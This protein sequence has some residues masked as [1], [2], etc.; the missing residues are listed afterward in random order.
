MKSTITI[1]LFAC[2]FIT[3]FSQTSFPSYGKIDIADLQMK[4]CPI[5]AGSDAMVLLD[6][7]DIDY[8]IT[9]SGDIKL[10]I[11]KRIRIKIFNNKG[12]KRANIK[13]PYLYRKK[14]TKISDV[15]GIIYSI[16]STGRITTQKI[17]KGQIFK[18]KSEDDIK[19]VS[20]TFPNVQPGSVIEYRYTRTE[21][22]SIHLVPW[23][24]Q[25]DIPVRLSVYR[26]AIPYLS[27]LEKNVVTN[28]PVREQKESLYSALKNRF[29]FS[30][31]NIYAFKSE[32][33][34]GSINDNL[35]RMEFF[36]KPGRFGLVNARLST[37]EKWAVI[38]SIFTDSSFFGSHFRKNI[39]STQYILDSAGRLSSPDEKIGYIYHHVKSKMKWDKVRTF[40][41]EDL[42]ECWKTKSGNS[43]EINLILLNLL[44]KCNIQAHALLTSTHEN[45]K[46]NK[47]FP[48]PGQFNGVA[49]FARDTING[50][51][52]VLDGTVTHGSYKIPPFNILNREAFLLDSL[53]GRW[54]YVTDTRPLM[55]Q[56][57]SAVAHIDS[58][59]LIKGEALINLSDY[60]KDIYFSS[61]DKKE[62]DDDE[63]EIKAAPVTFTGFTEENTENEQLPLVQKFN[64]RSETEKAGDYLLFN[65]SLLTNFRKNPFTSESRQTDIEFGCN[66]QYFINIT[67]RLPGDMNFESVPKNITLINTDSTLYFRRFSA[68]EGTNAVCRMT[69]EIRKAIFS[70]EEY[71]EIKDFY[72]KLFDL[73][74]DQIVITKKNQ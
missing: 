41:A 49:I 12:L 9:F 13:I 32:P 33:Y 27:H 8:G 22:S 30:A 59:T 65:P 55:R 42:N 58:G 37:D 53:N 11:D 1:A 56:T 68:Y 34:M 5:D 60:A 24:L 45:G 64:F 51:N 23:V 19:E 21:K 31:Q 25:S 61:K 6:Y 36:L 72:K 57:F 71:P 35:H 2:Y 44:R 70:K 3:G 52:Y 48:N 29:T 26:I 16:G 62:D 20:F 15:S 18:N 63:F 54:V 17:E 38:N 10:I 28:L 47:A 43:A 39:D 4:E 66:Q 46:I 73:L 7:T 14:H 74:K 50:V 67:L 40:Y 69:L